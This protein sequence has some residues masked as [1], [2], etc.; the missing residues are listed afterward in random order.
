MIKIN[1]VKSKYL[2]IVEKGNNIKIGIGDMLK[3]GYPRYVEKIQ[4]NR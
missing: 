1:T 3:C 4:R 2:D